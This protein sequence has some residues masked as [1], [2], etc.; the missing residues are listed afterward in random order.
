MF[1]ELIQRCK[2]AQLTPDQAGRFAVV[3]E[4]VGRW[5]AAKR[6]KVEASRLKQRVDS[7]GG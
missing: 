2:R 7:T 4:A 5:K 6:E 1:K 3:L